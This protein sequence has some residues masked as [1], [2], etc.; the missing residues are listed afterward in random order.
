MS[1]R[2]AENTVYNCIHVDPEAAATG[3]RIA[4]H[5]TK[6]NYAACH[7]IIDEF[8]EARAK[9]PEELEYI[10]QLSL[11]QRTLNI[12][13]K[14]GY[15]CI[16]ELTEEALVHIREIPYVGP[17]VWEDIRRALEEYHEGIRSAEAS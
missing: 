8:V 17:V 5:L 1:K 10:A 3:T 14:E 4:I 11:S 6:K 16:D 9:A 15:L 2:A 7:N 12:L 13:D